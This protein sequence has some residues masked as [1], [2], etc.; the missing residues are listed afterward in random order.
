MNGLIKRAG[1]FFVDLVP[2]ESPILYRACKRYVDRYNGENNSDIRT[3]GELRFMQRVLP[4]CQTIFD[5]GAN[6]G[7]WTAL[8]LSINGG[9]AVHCF[10]PSRFTYHKLLER[11]F[12]PRVICNN[13]GLSSLVKETRLHVFE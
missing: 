11:G 13:F 8:A 9:L 10:E 3:N 5:V 2:S 1:R 7:D 12:P 4:R 6:V